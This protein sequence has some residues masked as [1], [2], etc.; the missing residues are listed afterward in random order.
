MKRLRIN[1]F[2]I[3]EMRWPNSGDFWSEQY[4]VIYSETEQRRAEMKKVGL[5]LYRT[6]GQKVKEC[7]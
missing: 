6:W 3:S 4:Q 2:G 1:I 5:V 7:V